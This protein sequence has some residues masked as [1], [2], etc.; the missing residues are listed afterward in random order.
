MRTGWGKQD[1]WL[2]MPSTRPVSSITHPDNNG[3]SLYAYG[4]HLLAN[5]GTTTP[6]TVDGCAQI[7]NDSYRAAPESY[8]KD[9][10]RPVY[11]RAGSAN[12]YRTPL[13]RRWH[14]SEF[15]DV[16]EGEYRGPFA[17]TAPNV[18]IDDVSHERQIIFVRKLGLWI[19]VDRLKSP[20]QHSYEWVWPFY[21]P[22]GDDAQ[23]YPGFKWSQIEVDARTQSIK[24][25]NPAGPN[26]S[27][28]SFS[29]EPME[30]T[31]SGFKTAKRGDWMVVTVLYP[32]KFEHGEVAPDLAD[33]TPLK[34]AEGQC[35]FSAT[36]PGGGKVMF[37]AAPAGGTMTFQDAAFEG[38]SLLLAT[39]A[40]GTRGLVAL[41]CKRLALG[42]ARR[43]VPADFES[44]AKGPFRRF[45]PIYRPL[46]LPVIGPVEDRFSD[47]LQVTLTHNDPAVELRYTLDGTD[48]LGDSPLYGGPIRIRRTSVVKARACGSIATRWAPEVRLPAT[49][50]GTEAS[51]VAR[52]VFTREGL[53][54]AAKPG[55]TKDRPTNTFRISRTSL[56]AREEGHHVER[57]EYGYGVIL[58]PTRSPA[59]PSTA[60]RTTARGPSRPSAW[61]PC[62]PCAAVRVRS[63][64]TSAPRR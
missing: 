19:V 25:D 11:G 23:R 56:A 61:T 1:Q 22:S 3:F 21:C 15:F 46:D 12:A 14:T 27:L 62:S 4:R 58:R 29:P 32:R 10:F 8:R 30:K 36:I 2:Y 18:F 42:G 9:I 33:L 31:G 49:S 38:Q 54:Q 16:L 7:G 53:W 45:D 35:G 43:S 5:T 63:C 55:D 64:S 17:R 34:G 26:L 39:M 40:D 57:D 47:E 28:C 60:M 59:W 51:A 44:V 24:T 52:A 20:T 41:G 13:Q 50:D 6:V 37:Q 48:P